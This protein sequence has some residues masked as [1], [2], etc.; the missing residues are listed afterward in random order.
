V[1]PQ[2]ER[3]KKK[4]REEPTNHTTR[5]PA[6]AKL[7]IRSTKHKARN[8]KLEIRNKTKKRRK[9]EENVKRGEKLQNGSADWQ[10]KVFRTRVSSGFPLC[11]FAPLRDNS[12]LRISCDS[13]GSWAVFTFFP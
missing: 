3:G 1:K 2:P 6:A 11:G 13:R 7:E 9:Q 5:P 4:K 12:I 10:T 8:P